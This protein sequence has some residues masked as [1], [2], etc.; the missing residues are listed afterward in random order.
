MSKEQ[1]VLTRVASLLREMMAI[2]GT[3]YCDLPVPNATLSYVL[4]G[5]NIRI[6]TLVKIADALGCD[7]V[8][9]LRERPRQKGT[10]HVKP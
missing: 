1:V 2:R 6:A 9:H 10:P 5:R 7:V 8:I 4:N 3:R